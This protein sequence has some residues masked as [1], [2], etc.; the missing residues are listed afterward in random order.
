MKIAGK[1][2]IL[3]GATLWNLKLEKQADTRKNW[4]DK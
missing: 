2:K 3:E 4:L 1:F